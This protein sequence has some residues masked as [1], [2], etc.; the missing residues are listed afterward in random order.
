VVA[1]FRD[2]SEI[3]RIDTLD[4]ALCLCNSV[5][6]ATFNCARVGLLQRPAFFRMPKNPKVILPE[7]WINPRSN[8]KHLS[9]HSWDRRNTDAANARYLELADVALKAKGA[10]A[11]QFAV[12]E[13]IADE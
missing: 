1:S 13:L 9:H 11:D 10:V 4:P 7:M 2:T 8:L 3:P 5:Q 12:P 6:R